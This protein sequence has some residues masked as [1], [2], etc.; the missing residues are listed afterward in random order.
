MEVGYLRRRALSPQ[1]CGVAEMEDP[2]L[3]PSPQE[4]SL[5]VGL[6]ADLRTCGD[7]FGI[8][9]ST[10]PRGPTRPRT[11]TGRRGRFSTRGRR[12]ARATVRPGLSVAARVPS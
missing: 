8:S 5:V 9:V 4:F 2:R 6:F 1:F 11:Q 7:R 10:A 3:F 12:T